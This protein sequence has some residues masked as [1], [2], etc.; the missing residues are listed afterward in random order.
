MENGL[1]LSTVT[2]LLTVVATL[3]LYGERIF[4][5]LV[6]RHFVGANNMMGA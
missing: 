3:P 1:G 2:R 4:A 5:L 6:L